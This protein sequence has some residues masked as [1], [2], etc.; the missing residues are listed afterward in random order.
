MKSDAQSR[1]QSAAVPHAATSTTVHSFD[2]TTEGNAPQYGLVQG[3]DGSL[4]GVTTHP[5]G[6]ASTSNIGIVFKVNPDGTGFTVLHAFIN[7]TD[8]FT[9]GAKLLLD[10]GLLL[11]TCTT[12]GGDNEAGTVFVIDPSQVK[13]G[14]N[15]AGFS[16]LHY[17][18][19]DVVPFAGGGS[20]LSPNTSDGAQPNG[21]LFLA[22][23]GSVYGTT[24]GPEANG[25]GG[26]I[27]HIQPDSSGHFSVTA[28]DV[29]QIYQFGGTYTTIYYF[30]GGSATPN[31]ANGANPLGGVIQLSDGFLY[32]T[33]YQGGSAAGHGTV[34]KIATDGSGFTI[35][36]SFTG[37]PVIT[38]GAVTGTGDGES[39]ECDL[40]QA[41]DGN[42]YGTTYFGGSGGAGTVF[43]IKPDSFGLFSANSP[44]GTIAAL[45][46]N[47]GNEAAGGVIQASD[48]NLYGTT[49]TG[50]TGGSGNGSIF[51][52]MPDP[53]TGKFDAVADPLTYGG[54][55]PDPFTTIYTFLGQNNPQGVA[56]PLNQGQDGR[57]YGESLNGG[58]LANGT[59]AAGTVFAINAGLP[60]PPFVTGVSGT[61]NPPS[62]TNG[63]TTLIVHGQ[64]FGGGDTV[65]IDGRTLP[66]TP[67]YDFSQ[68]DEKITVTLSVAL[69]AGP[70]T[71]TVAT[72]N[73]KAVSNAF[74]FLVTSLLPPIVVSSVSGTISPP[75]VTSGDTTLTVHG[76]GFG[77]GYTVAIDGVTIPGPYSFNLHTST[78]EQ[79]TVTLAGPLAGGTH[80]VVV[81]YSGAGGSAS[82]P[83]SFSV[84]LLSPQIIKVTNGSGGAV[85]TADTTLIVNGNSFA[86]GDSVF[87]GLIYAGTTLSKAPNSTGSNGT[88]ITVNLSQP[89]PPGDHNIIVTHG[90]PDNRASNTYDL[91]VQA[92]VPAITD[93]TGVGSAAPTTNDTTLTIHGTNFASSDAVSITGIPANESVATGNID[94]SNP[95]DEKITATLSSPLP[96]GTYNATVTGSAAFPFTVAAAPAPVISATAYAIQGGHGIV[97]V[98]G[99]NFVAGAT[100]S[101]LT[102]NGTVGPVSVSSAASPLVVTLPQT[103]PAGISVVYVTNPDG[104]QA[105]AP[106]YVLSITGV[107]YN[108]NDPSGPLVTLTGAG[109]APK[110]TVTIVDP[111]T[112]SLAPANGSVI[113]PFIVSQDGTSISFNLFNLLAAGHDR[114]VVTNPDGQ[115]G[116][117]DLYLPGI[118]SIQY[119]VTATGYQLLI[120]GVGFDSQ[121]PVTV[122]GTAVTVISRNGEQQITATGSPALTAGRHSVVVSDADG[123]TSTFTITVSPAPTIST[124]GS[125]FLNAAGVT[126]L[127]NSSGDTLLVVSGK[128]FV[129]NVNSGVYPNFT[130]GAYVDG[131]FEAATALDSALNSN[132]ETVSQLFVPLGKKFG[133]GPHSVVV[134]NP[135][136]SGSDGSV[137]AQARPGLRAAVT[138]Q[139]VS[140]HAAGATGQIY[141][142][143]QTSYVASLSPQNTNPFLQFLFG[144][145]NDLRAVLS[146][147]GSAV[148]TI[149]G[150]LAT[151][152]SH[153]PVMIT[154]S[155]GGVAA[156]VI[157]NDGGSI[158][159][160][161][162]GNIVAQGGGNI[163][164]QGGGNIVAQGG[165]NYTQGAAGGLRPAG[166]SQSSAAA[167]RAASASV[168]VV[169][170]LAT[171]DNTDP[172]GN[173]LEFQSS[174]ATVSA[175]PGVVSPRAGSA[176]G[177]FTI[178]KSDQAGTGPSDLTITAKDASGNPV[179]LLQM[180]FTPGQPDVVMYQ[181]P[182]LL[183]TPT[184]GTLA[185]VASAGVVQVTPGAFRTEHGH[186]GQLSQLLTLTN[187]TTFAVTGGLGVTL[188]GLPAGVTVLGAT[189]GAVPA[190]AHGLAGGATMQ[191]RVYFNAPG[192]ATF[193]D[194]AQAVPM[195]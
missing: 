29:N 78:D 191:M 57:L 170:L 124:G 160:Q 3:P 25:T 121:A 21:S 194:T 115:T 53:S 176:P 126:F 55:F 104:Q 168:P 179:T 187:P 105:N 2:P 15:A 171:L 63:D 73:G 5:A 72:P 133:D 150:G 24:Y 13:A 59:G 128:N 6:S 8:G 74:Q 111:A 142:H 189:G 93:V 123:A 177:S 173:S 67:S 18:Q 117:R 42:L 68:A 116:S 167:P 180:R 178:Q 61:T 103:L 99:S 96:T 76:T 82:S 65:A 185:P 140:P 81:S 184:S 60:A 95:A 186:Q 51:Q 26:T 17:F 174:S 100:V 75:S 79:I 88:Q 39:P 10:G 190:G 56:C 38:N 153:G 182:G 35:L 136:G 125:G 66:G 84:T 89:L 41:A 30:N 70:H 92:V 109:I 107:T 48:G 36:H 152:F 102:P 108:Q 127:T 86:A 40:I 172:S 146:G 164:A 183:L 77:G 97:T 83:F 64:N 91:T 23:D 44:F 69:P 62:V 166:L 175:R 192:R 154:A 58:Q 110:A 156:G 131:T 20:Q 138:R 193:T 162:G 122:D 144:A 163:V 129:T 112:G 19:N 22:S 101:V 161:G 28:P 12:G 11:G 34:Y 141:D 4:Y 46:N 147:L 118:A 155:G 31:P 106:L 113:T 94:L 7:G 149:L 135:D 148:Q 85:T 158:V 9:P 181:I 32:G 33:T 134:R 87:V 159:A 1:A 98:T 143:D 52:I 16:V 114:F 130:V 132:G 165:G 49:L 80:S 54:T 188:S 27:F 47:T 120:L 145:F 195:P 137:A 157:S 45:N 71:V 14:N 119:T 90:P 139:A 50:G 37:G 43:Q 151:A 169:G